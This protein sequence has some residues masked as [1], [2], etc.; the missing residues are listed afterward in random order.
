[1]TIS[2]VLKFNFHYYRRHILLTTLCLMGIALGVGIVV[3]V[4]LINDSALKSFSSSVD[5]LSGKSD[6]SIISE[7][8]RIDEKLFASI[9]SKPGV[10]S[11]APIIEVMAQTLQTGDDPVRFLGIDPFLDFQIRSFFPRKQGSVG[12]GFL[13][14]DPPGVFVS[15]HMMSKY[16]LAR[17]SILTVV[18]AGIE[19]KLT[20]RGQIPKSAMGAQGENIAIMDIARAQELFSKLGHIDR[21]DVMTRL[22][23]AQLGNGLPKDLMVI[24]S[25]SRKSTLKAMLYSFQL[26]LAAMSLLALFVGVFLIYNFSMFSVLSRRQDMSLLLMLGSDRQGLVGA[27]LLESLIFGA[28][29]SLLGILFGYL[30]AT[31]SIDRVSSTISDLYFQVNVD[32]VILTTQTLTHG[33]IVGFAAVFIGVLIPCLEVAVTPPV[34]GLTRRSIE[35]KVQGMKTWLFGAGA[36]LFI[37]A[38]IAA[39]ASKF[40]IF[41]GFASAFAMTTAF[42]LFTPLFLSIF[43]LYGGKFIKTILHSLE[44]FLAAR[45]VQASLSRTS[46]SV[47]ALATALAMT[48]GVDTMIHSFRGSVEEWLDGSLRGDLYI[49]PSTTRWHHALPDELAAMIKKDP[50]VDVMEKYSAYDIYLM[51]KP[52]RLRII[53]ADILESRV[54]FIFLK[55]SEKAAWEGIKKGGVFISES[56]AYKFHL[57]LGESLKL[58]TPR[59]ERSF[60]IVAITRDY[61]SDQGTIQMDRQVYVD[62]WGDARTQSI[63]IFAKLNASLDDLKSRIASTFPGLG[64]AISSN[65]KM[66][67]GVLL[68]FDKTFA[69]TA[70]LKGVSLLVALLGVATA[71]TAILIERSRDMRVLGFLGLT[72]NQLGLM[73]VF[74]AMFMGLASFLIAAVSGLFITLIIIFAINYRSFGWSIDIHLSSWVFLKSFLLTSLACFVASLYPTWKILKTHNVTVSDE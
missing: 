3:A 8:G 2:T 42:A 55:G 10:Q 5:Y 74:Q 57:S 4:E 31:Y 62:D 29:G 48:I 41:W 68:I 15:S 14:D 63:A 35:E 16:G 66:R 33:L 17:G 25:N 73:N 28:A 49:A 46:I 56:L 37:S 40:S 38:G 30:V 61:S 51:G 43:A 19:H 20:V 39:W 21:I 6:L 27:F 34:V 24:D 32:S 1:M 52:V 13:T 23:A 50:A 67:R 9:W 64:K 65:E 22:S 70:T 60:K 71:L 72:P 53:E 59:G 54:K 12:G 45:A 7:Q 18:I 36:V 47:A 26:N 44:G 58:N 11:A 69:P